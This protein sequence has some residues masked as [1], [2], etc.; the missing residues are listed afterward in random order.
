MSAEERASRVPAGKPPS[1]ALRPLDYALLLF[2]GAIWGSAFPVIRVGLVHGAAPFFFAGVRCLL[3]AVGIALMAWATREAV[4]SSR[5]LRVSAVLGAALTIGGYFVFLYVGEEAVPGGL[6]SIV[7][8]TNPLWS[9]MFALPL[10]PSERLGKFG[11]L[12]IFAGFVGVLVIFLPDL[13]GS[14]RVPLLPLLEVLAA[15]A[16]FALGSVLL[17]HFEPGPQGFWGISTQLGAG[18]AAMTAGA[19]LVPAGTALPLTADV[20]LPLVYLVLV[21]TCIGYVVYFRL[22][23]QVGPTRANLVSFIS[24]IS[25]LLVGLAVSEGAPSLLEVGGLALVALGL[26]LVGRRKS[27]TRP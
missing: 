24:P 25:G 18:G 5:S 6:A 27:T 2:L 17:R 12:G 13:G 7:V 19:F 15:P 3:G 20:L 23:H 1:S 11:A 26:F 9:A 16:L 22:H 10:L 21:P 14:S 4:P 8:A